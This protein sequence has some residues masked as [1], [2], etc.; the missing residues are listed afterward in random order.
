MFCFLV[1]RFRKKEITFATDKLKIES[2]VQ[3]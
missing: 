3:L 2:E 1:S